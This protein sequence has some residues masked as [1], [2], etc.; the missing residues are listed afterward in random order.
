[1]RAKP[2]FLLALSVLVAFAAGCHTLGTRNFKLEQHIPPEARIPNEE[3][4]T[5][6]PLYV[7]EPPDILLIDALRVIP[8]A[9]YRLEPLDIVQIESE[10]VL[11]DYPITG[12]YQIDASG[13]VNL[14]S[15]YG[16]VTI[17]G[18]T[19]D[20]A[21]TAIQD[22]LLELLVNPVTTVKLLETAGSQQIAGEH[23]VAPDGMVN[24]GSYGQV[25]VAGLTLEQ[26]KDAIEKKLDEYLEAPEVIV[27]VSAYNSK[28]YY[29]ISDG[30]GLGDQVVRLPINGGETVLDAISEIGG[31]GGQATKD[32]WIARPS[33]DHGGYEQRLP[34]NWDAICKQGIT[35]TNYQV[36]PGDR[37]YIRA[38]ELNRLDATIA[39]VTAPVER[40]AGTMFLATATIRNLGGS[41]RDSGN[42]NFGNFFSDRRL[43]TDIRQVA[44]SPSGIPVYH[45]RYRGQ[46]QWYRGVIAQDLLANRSA[47]VVRADNGYLMVN[48]GLLDV[49]FRELTP[50]EVAA[51]NRLRRGVTLPAAATVEAKSRN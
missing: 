51:E 22:K 2:A 21:E 10:N 44:T 41:F 17:S 42:N 1:M 15:Q 46:M 29:V 30:A 33:P 31:L 7:V 37:I 32:I 39:R 43:K 24:L 14:G 19:I 50:A 4:K 9:P 25:Y 36:F 38:S 48:Y 20:E 47:A 6:L 13:R 23:Q 8:K 11:P 12:E 16:K 27:D 34:V 5:T 40:I 45:F 26:V 18:K 35:A 28:F 49:E 3:F